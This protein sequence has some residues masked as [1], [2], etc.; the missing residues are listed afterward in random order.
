MSKFPVSPTF[1]KCPPL[2]EDESSYITRLGQKSFVD[3]IELAQ[4][5]VG[6]IQ[7]TL[8]SDEEGLQIYIGND[9]LSQTN[10]IYLCSITE[11][12]ATIDEAAGLFRLATTPEFK[13]YSRNF[14]TD[15]IDQASLYT[16]TTPSIHQPRHYVGVKWIVLESPYPMVSNRDWCYLEYQDDFER[17][18][19]KGWA[20]S[21]N[22]IKLSCCPDLEQSLGLVRATFHRSGF[23]FLE[24]KRKGY[25]QVIHMLQM[26]LGGNVP[27][28]IVRAGMKRRAKSIIN[29]DLYLRQKRLS[30]GTFLQGHQLI[31]PQKR[32]KCFL[33]HEKFGVFGTKHN[34]TKCGE[35]T[36]KKCSKR[37]DI[38]APSGTRRLLRVCSACSLFGGRSISTASLM[39]HCKHQSNSND[40]ESH[41]G[42]IHS[43]DHENDVFYYH[44]NQ[45]RQLAGTFQLPTDTKYQKPLQNEVYHKSI[46]KPLEKPTRLQPSQGTFQSFPQPKQNQQNF[47]RMTMNSTYVMGD[48]NTMLS[49][50]DE[51]STRMPTFEE[52]EPT[53][54]QTTQ[55]CDSDTDMSAYSEDTLVHTKNVQQSKIKPSMQKNEAKAPS[56]MTFRASYDDRTNKIGAQAKS[57]SFNA[58][59]HW[60]LDR[61][62]RYQKSF[63]QNLLQMKPKL[64]LPPNYFSSPALSKED[65]CHLIKRGLNS[66]TDL[67]LSSRFDGGPIQ[68]MLDS[69]EDG[70]RIFRGLDPFAPPGVS[71]CF[72]G[73]M[74]IQATLPEVAALFR[75]DTTQL[76]QEYCAR[77]AKDLL[78]CASLYTL[79]APTET[80]PHNYIGVKWLAV[81]LP[82]PVVK[83]R[84]W[85][86][87]E[88]QDDFDINGVKGW[89]RCF[90]SITMS[91]CPEID[92]LVRAS[93]YR[94]GYIFLQSEKPG[95]LQ[96]MHII[97]ADFKGAIPP[98]LLNFGMI[99]RLKHLVEINKF[100]LE[101]RLGSTPTLTIEEL[102][103]LSN[104][105][106]CFLCNRK[107]NAFTKKR[108]CFKCGEVVC[109]RCSKLWH[110]NIKHP[111]LQVCNKCS[112]HSSSYNHNVH[113]QS[114]KSV[115]E[116]EY[117]RHVPLQKSYSMR[118]QTT[119]PKVE[120]FSSWD[121]KR[122]DPFRR[123]SA[124]QQNDAFLAPYYSNRDHFQVPTTNVDIPQSKAVE[125]FDV[126]LL[127]ATPEQLRELYKNLK[128][129]GIDSTCPR[130]EYEEENYYRGVAKSTMKKL[131][132]LNTF[133]DGRIR[134]KS[135]GQIANAAIFQGDDGTSLPYLCAKT[136]VRGSI[137]EI[138]QLFRQDF[139]APGQLN[140]RR[141]FPD[142][143]DAQILYTLNRPSAKAP[144]HYLGLVWMALESTATLVKRR[145]F[146]FIENH[147]DF[148]DDSGRKG[149]AQSLTSV[150]LDCCPELTHSL[151]L[152]RG[153]L[154]HTG[155]VVLE[156]NRLGV[157]EVTYF[158]QADY[159]GSVPRT[160]LVSSMRHH[161]ASI[162]LLESLILKERLLVTPFLQEEELVPKMVRKTC[163]VCLQAFG[164][165]Q[166]RRRCR[167]CGEVVC[168]NC[169]SHIQYDGLLDCKPERI[170]VC[171]SCVNYFLQPE[172]QR[173]VTRSKSLLLRRS[174]LQASFAE[175]SV[176]K[177]K[178][179]SSADEIEA[180]WSFE[181]KKSDDKSMCHPE[182]AK[183]DQPVRL[184]SR[185][186]SRRA[187]L[188]QTKSLGNILEST[189]TIS[190]SKQSREHS[191][192]RQRGSNES[193]G[194]GHRDLEDIKQSLIL[195]AWSGNT[196]AEPVHVEEVENLSAL[197]T[198]EG[199][200]KP[201]ASPRDDSHDDDDNDIQ[202]ITRFQVQPLLIGY[203]S[204]RAGN[205]DNKKYASQNDY[206][207]QKF[208]CENIDD[209][210]LDITEAI[211]TQCSNINAVLQ[212]FRSE[213][214]DGEI[215]PLSSLRC[216]YNLA[217][218]ASALVTQLN[219]LR[220]SVI[221]II[222]EDN[223]PSKK[224][225]IDINA[226]LEGMKQCMNSDATQ[227]VYAKRVRVNPLWKDVFALP[228]ITSIETVLTTAG[229]NLEVHYNGAQ[230][231]VKTFANVKDLCLTGVKL[232]KGIEKFTLSGVNLKSVPT[233]LEW[234]DT[235]KHI[236]LSSNQL[237]TFPA[238]VALPDGLQALILYGNKIQIFSDY[239]SWPSNL[240]ELNL[241]SN[242]LTTVIKF[243]LTLSKLDL[244]SNPLKS[245]DVNQ[246]WPGDLQEL[247]NQSILELDSNGIDSIPNDFQVSSSLGILSLDGNKLSKLPDNCSWMAKLHSLTLRDNQLSKLPTKCTLPS[248]ISLQNNN[249]TALEDL[250]LPK[251]MDLSNNP[252][253]KLNRVTFPKGIFWTTSSFVLKEFSLS[254][255]MFDIL[256]SAT[257]HTYFT[258]S[259][260]TDA[261]SVKQA[262]IYGS[263]K[264]LHEFNVTICVV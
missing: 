181:K 20:R 188:I 246:Q 146:C 136:E 102:V 57:A 84:D 34:C 253:E 163:Q 40:G 11:V 154:I 46:P 28:F 201:Q 229:T 120:R 179:T 3:L 21:F 82:T 25:L 59:Q 37:W 81:G 104:R 205:G 174:S 108:Q 199:F 51:I 129:M 85:C 186:D 16:I 87:L 151:G 19:V 242:E 221:E 247:Y 258:P 107:F 249:I 75:L 155:C 71:T 176:V 133:Q 251:Q 238:T 228:N 128:A 6:S 210:S 203:K 245:I 264:Q 216:E 243:P 172:Q 31:D 124:Q 182:K 217:S 170:R 202:S 42:S 23:V 26:D 109:K 180:K 149:W 5:Q 131:I 47:Q 76:F 191:Y 195:K 200:N 9:L 62:Q 105:R 106:Q 169:S 213:K 35:V 55:D 18:G 250:A 83:N 248:S 261:A 226:L 61:N 69:N 80:H 189:P 177:L 101:Q 185:R 175:P 156:T 98:W 122:V 158:V 125:E 72:C 218:E 219:G 13:E 24:S 48:N 138:S 225:N 70:V 150:R 58:D 77:F 74:E 39:D 252:I 27:E 10:M 117:I 159:K 157:L 32:S 73:V 141:I 14:A 93:F 127:N 196:H 220:E 211:L 207:F 68:W 140:R 160:M 139:E 183:L 256:S 114:F 7:W 111:L 56:S 43:S 38:M 29:I 90:N 237:T 234:P 118:Y 95:Y 119:Q 143:L 92:G 100:L 96:C 209:E 204:P 148:I 41:R 33:C 94:A 54:L 260:T 88:C 45:H 63:R 12:F 36:C 214:E 121:E 135:A 166:R 152:V 173:V 165:F 263:I 254:S 1:F 193:I 168:L 187:S 22:S 89:A 99:R 215:N 206:S 212:S 235:L 178:S 123:Y 115:Q 78:D 137:E 50:S 103:P 134:W 97:Q 233:T 227:C 126:A 208:Y 86:V 52:F 167:K 171:S 194:R 65:E 17:D 147:D 161:L 164:A 30:Q 66:L 2:S 142:T 44:E 231:T 162:S 223:T 192:H 116:E 8:D 132:Q 197:C 259:F 53:E 244:S 145:D 232:P 241:G 49:Q 67:V 64:P 60:N 91:C 230:Q 239:F 153:S 240:T 198:F 110:I 79:A 236:D 15:L 184:P 262:C 190:E 4:L 113:E 144:R 255:E 222:K 224:L 130:M 112:L 257:D